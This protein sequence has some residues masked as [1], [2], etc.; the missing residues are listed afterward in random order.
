[1]DKRSHELDLY[2]T[3]V[4]TYFSV[5][6]AGYP[7]AVKV[8]TTYLVT[9]TALL[10]YLNKTTDLISQADAEAGIATE[11]KTFSALRVW[12]AIQAWWSVQVLKH[13]LYFEQESDIA[14][15]Y[16]KD[17]LENTITER[18]DYRW[19]SG[20]P[21]VKIGTTAGGDDIL[22][23]MEVPSNKSLV[24]IITYP[25]DAD[26]TVYITVSGGILDIMWI[27]RKDFW[28]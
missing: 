2:S 22:T 27:Y 12:Q 14:A 5:D 21:L 6:K 1:M 19:K 16:T 3:I 11:G 23:E 15:S 4:G 24:N 10:N 25:F 20:T 8:P 18:I 17:F 13:P 28:T 9:N 7:E 26:T